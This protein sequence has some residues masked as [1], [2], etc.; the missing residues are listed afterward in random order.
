MCHFSGRWPATKVYPCLQFR[1]AEVQP[2]LHAAVW[3]GPA[4]SE[5]VNRSS[6]QPCY[7]HGQFDLADLISFWLFLQ[8]LPQRSDLGGE[9]FQ[10][11]VDRLERIG[12]RL[13]RRWG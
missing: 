6:R 7:G 1:A 2:S 3:D 13:H 4:M 10:L 9:F 12:D 11:G 5:L 8:R